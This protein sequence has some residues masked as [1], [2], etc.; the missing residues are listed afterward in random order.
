MKFSLYMSVVQRGSGRE[1]SRGMNRPQTLL[2]G[3]YKNVEGW[4]IDHFSRGSAFRVRKVNHVETEV[5][6]YGLRTSSAR[7]MHQFPAFEY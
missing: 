4:G 3:L 2:N 1:S 7:L 5:V 6:V